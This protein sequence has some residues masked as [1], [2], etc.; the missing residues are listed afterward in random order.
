MVTP[1]SKRDATSRRLQKNRISAQKCRVKRKERL[2]QLEESHTQC[3]S[4][5]SEVDALRLALAKNEYQIAS[6]KSKIE[7]AT[8]QMED[9]FFTYIFGD[10]A[11]GGAFQECA[12]IDTPAC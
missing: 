9:F 6:M 1:D 11:C 3:R 7:N 2:R 5:Q 10:L 4:L 8:A 12:R